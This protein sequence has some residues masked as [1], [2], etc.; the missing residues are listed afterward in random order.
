[1]MVYMG[2]MYD[3]PDTDKDCSEM[4]IFSFMK[5]RK[6]QAIVLAYFLQIYVRTIR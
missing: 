3:C 5:V 6:S 4:D 1:M 2:N